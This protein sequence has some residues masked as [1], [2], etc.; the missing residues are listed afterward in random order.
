MKEIS[1]CGVYQDHFIQIENGGVNC[2]L[3]ALMKS[4]RLF[5]GTR[6]GTD[7]TWTEV[8]MPILREV[9]LP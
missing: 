8:T 6:S 7:M 3:W 4:G 9:P 5:Y 2:V 1:G